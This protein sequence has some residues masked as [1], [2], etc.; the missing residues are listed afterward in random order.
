[1]IRSAK[2]DKNQPAIVEALRK[3][4]FAVVP[5]HA[6]GNGCPDL[7]VAKMNRC[8]LQEVKCEDGANSAKNRDLAK[9]LTPDQ[10]KFHYFWQG[11]IDVVWTPE[12]AVEA[13][14]K[15]VEF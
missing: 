4:G 8:W 6:V 14:Q 10:H 13:A 15:R 3:A 11:P 12:E 7:L 5:L 2:V 1:M 9:C